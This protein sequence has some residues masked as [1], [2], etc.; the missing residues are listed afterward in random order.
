M[1]ATG[2]PVAQPRRSA[3]DSFK[4]RARNADSASVAQVRRNPRQHER[5]SAP[6]TRATGIH[7]EFHAA[8]LSATGAIQNLTERGL[9]IASGEHPAR[10]ACVTI[11]FTTPDKRRVEVSGC[12][13]WIRDSGRD[14]GFGVALA[15][16]DFEYRAFIARLLAG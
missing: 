11:R 2:N 10:G 12:V 15:G 13:G 14:Q 6:R 7:V 3:A 16:V 4:C 9:F 8:G 5:R 1:P